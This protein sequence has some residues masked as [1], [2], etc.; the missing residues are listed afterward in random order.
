M[1]IALTFRE[2]QMKLVTDIRE[3]GAMDQFDFNSCKICKY[4]N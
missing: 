2:K 4:E 1:K 3:S